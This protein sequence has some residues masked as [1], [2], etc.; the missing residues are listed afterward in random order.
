MPSKD[1]IYLYLKKNN[2]I[3]FRVVHIA[4]LFKID[5]KRAGEKLLCLYKNK[6]MYKGLDRESVRR[7][8]ENNREFLCYQYF[9]K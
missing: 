6:G 9:V 2:G 1:E 8:A 5:P 4:K 3:K 7:I